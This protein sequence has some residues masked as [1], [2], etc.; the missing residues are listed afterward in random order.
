[1]LYNS[2]TFP[3]YS[4]S[5]RYLGNPQV[6]NM[7]CEQ[8]D[9]SQDKDAALLLASYQFCPD[10]GRSLQ[11]SSPSSN[12]RSSQDRNSP[13]PALSPGLE[14]NLITSTS[15]SAKLSAVIEKIHTCPFPSKQYVSYTTLTIKPSKFRPLTYI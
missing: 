15:Y 13:L 10:C 11:A 5:Q 3:R 6:E 8:C 2:R 7:G 9:T 4:S 1:M 12:L 14:E